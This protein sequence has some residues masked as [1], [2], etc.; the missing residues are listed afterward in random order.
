MAA[1]ER[2][3]AGARTNSRTAKGGVVSK[4]HLGRP[5]AINC[6]HCKKHGHGWR[7]CTQYVWADDGK[8]WKA[9]EKGK[10]W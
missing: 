9:S 8:K 3:G 4:E 10:Q 2:G 5:L 7:D 1:G 6:F